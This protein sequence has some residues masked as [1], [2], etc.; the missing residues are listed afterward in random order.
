MNDSPPIDS[1]PNETKRGSLSVGTPD[2]KSTGYP[3]SSPTIPVKDQPASHRE[4]L[5]SGGTAY[6]KV[7]A[8]QSRVVGEECVFLAH[9]LLPESAVL[10]SVAV[11]PSRKAFSGWSLNPDT[12]CKA[13]CDHCSRAGD[14][15]NDHDGRPWH[16]AP[17]TESIASPVVPV[18]LLVHGVA[19]SEERREYL[20]VEARP[21]AGKVPQETKSSTGMSGAFKASARGTARVL[22]PD[23]ERPSMPTIRTPL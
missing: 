14:A 1:I 6:S 7:C 4:A 16:S 9:P 23:P 11:E 21:P 13:V 19:T 15:L 8:T 2:R 20:L 22:F 17:R 12:A 18:P 10:A 3:T 5:R